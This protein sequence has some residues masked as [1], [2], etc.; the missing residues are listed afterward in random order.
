MQSLSVLALQQ[1][2]VA[3]LKS[4]PGAGEILTQFSFLADLTLAKW[5]DPTSSTEFTFSVSSDL[6]RIASV[7]FPHYPGIASVEVWYKVGNSWSAPQTVSAGDVV[8]FTGG[9]TDVKFEG[10][11]SNGQVVSLPDGFLFEATF[12]SSGQVS[13]SLDEI[14]VTLQTMTAAVAV[15]ATMYNATGTS[16]EITNLTNNFLPAQVA[17]ATQNGLN[18]LV[19]ACEVLGLAFAFGNETGGTA[20]ANNFGPS[21]GAMP[22]TTAGDAAFATAASVRSSVWHQRQIWSP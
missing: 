19:Y 18:P 12:A 14:D 6:P 2:I 1:G 4:V 5:F 21:N 11:S 7:M 16:A 15:E 13:A 9:T 17:N 8:S 20:F 3:G 22:N 10:I